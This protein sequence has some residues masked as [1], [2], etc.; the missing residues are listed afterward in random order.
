[1]SA[2]SVEG[3]YE[4]NSVYDVTSVWMVFSDISVLLEYPGV[5]LRP[6]V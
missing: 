5:Y 3:S 1:M 6:G 4:S 2:L